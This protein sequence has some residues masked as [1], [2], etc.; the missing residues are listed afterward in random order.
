MGDSGRRKKK[1][2]KPQLLASSRARGPCTPLAG[3][4]QT[5]Q[6]GW[7]PLLVAAVAGGCSCWWLLGRL[8]SLTGWDCDGK[9][10][11]IRDVCV[12]FWTVP[13]PW[14]V[15]GAHSDQEGMCR[16]YDTEGAGV[17][18]AVACVRAVVCV[19]WRLATQGR[20]RNDGGST[21][22]EIECTGGWWLDLD[23]C[24][25]FRELEQSQGSRLCGTRDVCCG[26]QPAVFLTCTTA[27]M[28]GHRAAVGVGV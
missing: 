4:A 20:D 15:H 5:G 28:V 10:P 16:V 18:S 27:D 21:V 17:N 6:P 12:L 2:K 3:G 11:A 26:G 8:K 23:S 24:S 1:K 22:G 14:S 19:P 25:L 13:C 9:C 7:L